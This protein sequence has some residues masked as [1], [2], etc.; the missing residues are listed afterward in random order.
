[1]QENLGLV[2]LVGLSC[3]DRV[4]HTIEEE[5]IDLD[6]ATLI[7]NGI[8]NAEISKFCETHNKDYISTPFLK[9]TRGTILYTECPDCAR[10]REE[11]RKK[12]HIDKIQTMKIEKTE[13]R[14]SVLRAR[15]CGKRFISMISQIK[16]DTQLIR[17]GLSK[18]LE[19]DAS[20]KKFLINENLIVLGCCGIGKTFFGN[21]MVVKAYEM[22]L[23]YVCFTA[24]EL[25]C[26]YKS[27]DIGGFSR[28][29]SFD[30]LMDLIGDADCLI[31][32]EIDYFLRG[33]KDVRD[34]EALHHISQICEKEDIRLIILG[35]CN[36]SELKDGIPPKVSS[37]LAGAS[38]INGWD[39]EDMREK[40]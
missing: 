35:N 12:E 36:K 21:M 22:G 11:R 29:N 14:N 19:V 25:S 38:V 20:S 32:D 7:K 23:K 9:T 33:S 24:F 15:G 26:A 3:G 28:T 30:N 39:M 27:K 13:L 4:V 40:R 10:D 8:I 18:F 34:E 17:N 2:G 5:H 31:I 16:K 1:M 6:L 37:R